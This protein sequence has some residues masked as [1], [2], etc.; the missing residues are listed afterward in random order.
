MK[1]EIYYSNRTANVSW[2]SSRLESKG[3]QP[4]KGKIL[5][6]ANSPVDQPYKKVE[7]GKEKFEKIVENASV[8]QQDHLVEDLLDFLKWRERHVLH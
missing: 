5:G 7:V 3:P 6:F 2:L 8:T 1:K 4:C